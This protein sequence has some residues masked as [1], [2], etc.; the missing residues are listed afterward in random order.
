[1]RESGTGAHRHEGEADAQQKYRS[2]RTAS[3]RVPAAPSAAA[4]V[5]GGGTLAQD[6]SLPWFGRCWGE[7]K[8]GASHRL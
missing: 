2:G 7:R 1:M 3:A 4:P 5:A 8:V 6:R